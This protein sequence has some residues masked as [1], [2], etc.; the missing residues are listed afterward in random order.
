METHGGRRK[1]RGRNCE[2]N[3]VLELIFKKSGSKSEKKR[4][5]WK[6]FE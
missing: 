3:E 2:C 4:E 5:K 1:E 6:D